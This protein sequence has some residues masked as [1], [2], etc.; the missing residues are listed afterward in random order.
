[1]YATGLNL[2]E[3]IVCLPQIVG[4]WGNL[5]IC[6]LIAIC[7]FKTAMFITFVLV[8]HGILHCQTGVRPSSTD[9]WL[10]AI[11]VPRT[12]VASPTA[13]TLWTAFV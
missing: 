12:C 3:A 4:L 1:M 5:H 2:E 8:Y 13:D 11:L 9:L 10:Q 6:W 7:P